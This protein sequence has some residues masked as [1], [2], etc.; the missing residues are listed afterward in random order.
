MRLLKLPAACLKA[1]LLVLSEARW[2][3]TVVRGDDGS[4]KSPADTSEQAPLDQVIEFV[5]SSRAFADSRVLDAGHGTGETAR[6]LD[7]ERGGEMTAITDSR[8]L[9]VMVV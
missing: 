2:M 4:M 6:Y 1:A 7:R 3:A 8:R 9:V 5:E